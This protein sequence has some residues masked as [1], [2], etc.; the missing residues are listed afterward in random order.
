MHLNAISGLPSVPIHRPAIFAVKET[1]FECNRKPTWILAVSV[2]AFIY[3]RPYVTK[4]VYEHL[5]VRFYTH[6]SVIR[7]SPVV[8]WAGVTNRR[9]HA[10]RSR[11]IPRHGAATVHRHNLNRAAII[12]GGQNNL[13]YMTIIA[14]Y[15]PPPIFNYWPDLC[16]DATDLHTILSAFSVLDSRRNGCCVGSINSP[17]PV[18]IMSV[19][20]EIFVFKAS[21]EIRYLRRNTYMKRCK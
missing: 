3:E 1:V 7:V 21:D 8:G 4:C 11:S 19:G 20:R 9:A 5:Y 10:A 17:V 6:W 12:Y 13:R 16:K 15:I 18:D 2:Q 14:H